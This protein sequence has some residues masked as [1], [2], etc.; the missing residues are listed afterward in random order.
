MVVAVDAGGVAVG[1]ANLNGVV[2][3]LRG[4]LGARLGLEHWQCGRRLESRTHLANE[5]LLLSRVVAGGAG[6]LVA[7]V[8]KLVTAGVAVGPGDIHARAARNVNLDTCWF[9]P[10]IEGSWHC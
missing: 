1:E 5:G 3:Y 10:R 2:A 4:S 7:Q 6:T 8:S 9:F